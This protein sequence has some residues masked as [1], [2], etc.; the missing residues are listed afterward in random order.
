MEWAILLLIAVIVGVHWWEY[1]NTVQEYT[2]AQPATAGRID[3][4]VV[5]EKT[6]VPFEIGSLPWRPEVVEKAGWSTGEEGPD[7]DEA[8]AETMGLP[9]GLT[10]IEESR[11]WWWLPGLFD[12]RVGRLSAGAL[13]PLTWVGAERRWIGCSHGGPLTLWLVHSRYRR[14]LPDENDVDPW[15]L[16]VADAPWIG[17]VQFIELVVRPGWCV[18]LPAHWGYAVS[19]GEGGSWW[20]IAD[21]HSPLSWSLTHSGDVAQDIVSRVS[22][23]LPVGEEE[24]SES[25]ITQNVEVRTL[26]E[27]E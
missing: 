20:W 15:N 26:G 6:P 12:V 3:R 2:I 17:R 24:E 22:S 5:G 21:Q 23:L 11:A 14:Y 10:E 27:K 16:T 8:L 19:A 13:A 1:S 18:G 7:G 4:S 25:F 9:T